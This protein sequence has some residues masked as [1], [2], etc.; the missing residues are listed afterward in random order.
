MAS[1]IHE[2]TEK[3][4]EFVKLYREQLKSPHL[5]ILKIFQSYH[6]EITKNFWS[7]IVH[8]SLMFCEKSQNKKK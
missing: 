6:E 4:K 3:L 2:F 8:I 1:L 5:F 7:A